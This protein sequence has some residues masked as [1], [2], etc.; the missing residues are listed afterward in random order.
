MSDAMTRL[1][2]LPT[3]AAPWEKTGQSMIF[4]VDQHHAKEAWMVTQLQSRPFNAD[5]LWFGTSLQDHAI[6]GPTWFDLPPSAV[7]GMA[8]VCHQRPKG[9]ALRCRDPGAALAH[10]RKLMAM[11]LGRSRILNFYNPVNWTALAMDA[12]DN[13]GCLLGPWDAVYTPAPHIN[14]DAQRWHEWRLE[15]PAAA[16]TCTWPLAFPDSVFATFK[17]VRWVYWLRE[18]PKHFGRVPDSELPRLA[19]NLDFLVKH[20]IGVD[21][22]LLEIPHL[23]INGELSDRTDLLPILTSSE[24]PHRKVAQLLEAV[25]P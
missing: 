20:R 4:I 9:I 2:N 1:L 5:L 19:R 14:P 23:I 18:N 10:A 21:E 8:K 24:R 17:D 15:T 3:L 7:T 16:E 11:P 22:D 12:G 6:K 25:Q 13:L